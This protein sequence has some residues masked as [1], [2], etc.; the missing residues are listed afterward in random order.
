M[1]QKIRIF[2]AFSKSKK[3]K[4][5]GRKSNSLINANTSNTLAIAEDSNLKEL[6]RYASNGT[7]RAHLRAKGNSG[8]LILVRDGKLIR[9][10]DGLEKEVI[11]TLKSEKLSADKRY[12][13]RK[14]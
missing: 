5:R 2:R 12:S 7:A 3:L 13:V 9:E 6:I 8:E 1:D 10:I 4:F 11:K 14:R